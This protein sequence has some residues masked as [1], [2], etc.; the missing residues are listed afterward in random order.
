M[1]LCLVFITLFG[2][3]PI[4]IVPTPAA[5]ISKTRRL[6]ATLSIGSTSASHSPPPTAAA[7]MMVTSSSTDPAEM[8]SKMKRGMNK[9]LDSAKALLK[10]NTKVRKIPYRM[11]FDTFT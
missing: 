2:S 8:G 11:S 9:V 1:A 3:P 5:P 7:A 4:Q 6:L 10:I